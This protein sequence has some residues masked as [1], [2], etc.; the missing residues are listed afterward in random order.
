MKW[1]KEIFLKYQTNNV[2]IYCSPNFM[3]IL[4]FA[5]QYVR[6]CFKSLAIFYNDSHVRN[7]WHSAP[8]FCLIGKAKS[9]IGCLLKQPECRCL[10]QLLLKNIMSS[11]GILKK[12]WSWVFREQPTDFSKHCLFL[13]VSIIDHSHL[14][15]R[16]L[17]F[18]V[19]S[20][21]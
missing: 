15:P 11:S 13:V 12:V 20:S 7:V 2:L 9:S 17:L 18:F 1:Y 10:S 4:S 8:F 3:Q 6:L 21:S 5:S 19:C 14:C 16:T